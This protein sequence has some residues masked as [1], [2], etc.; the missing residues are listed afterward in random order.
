V[1]VS[2]FATCFNDA[3]FPETARA[4]VSILE[5]LGFKV[6][7]PSAQTCCGQMHLN[8]GYP[9][10]AF[11]L[12]RRLAQV[13]RDAEA[14]VAP[15]ASCVAAFTRLV[16]EL[17]E[18]YGDDATASAVREVAPRT[19]ELSQFLIEV[20]GAEEL[21]ASFH[22]RVAYH[23]TCHSLRMLGIKEGPLR[24]LRA[25]RGLELVD[26]QDSEVCCGFGGTFSIKNPDVSV[27]MGSDKLVSLLQAR[28]EVVCALDNSCLAH[29]GGLAARCGAGV[30]TMH[31]AEILAS[32]E[33]QGGQ[34]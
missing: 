10:Y 1:Q 31:L 26:F 25:V 14:V 27:A 23:P 18:A 29:L 34:P 8:S 5:R 17:A 21:G 16:P 12:A 2:L 11:G 20:A 22:H 4:T 28:P 7:F 19:Y 9:S 33:D 15:S 6:R 3:L 13:F 24:L 32:N 30:A